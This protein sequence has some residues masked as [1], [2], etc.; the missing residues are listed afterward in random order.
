MSFSLNRQILIAHNIKCFT[1]ICFEIIESCNFL[2]TVPKR[3]LKPRKR[4]K[5]KK[6]EGLEVKESNSS[7]IPTSSTFLINK[8]LPRTTKQPA[9]ADNYYPAGIFKKYILLTVICCP[10]YRWL[11][12]TLYHVCK[13]QVILVQ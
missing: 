6:P 4:K 13:A 11:E 7:H 8:I 10:V 1:V 12:L 2:F 9:L 5:K 3:V